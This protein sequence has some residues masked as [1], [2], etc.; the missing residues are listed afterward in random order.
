MGAV[1][2]T[3]AVVVLVFIA[4]AIVVIF[5]IVLFLRLTEILKILKQNKT[6]KDYKMSRPPSKSESHFSNPLI[7]IY[8]P[9]QIHRVIR[10]C[11]T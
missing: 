2:A 1:V 6:K 5:E 7:N 8:S 4:V 9:I 11:L 3:I 10:C